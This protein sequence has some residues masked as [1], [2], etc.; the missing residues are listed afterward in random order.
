MNDIYNR[1]ITLGYNNIRK[2]IDIYILVNDIKFETS[3]KAPSTYK[4]VKQNFKE[5]GMLLVY[6][7]GDHGHLGHKYN[8]KF[9]AVHDYMHLKYK[10]TFSFDDEHILSKITSRLFRQIAWE[11]LGCTAWECYVIDKIVNA[12][13]SGQIEYYKEN[14][15]YIV[16]QAEFINDYLKVV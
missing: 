2:I 15:R 11:I 6:S 14:N 8:T 5:K 3:D 9:R 1:D 4:A 7:G 16:N 10:L 12:E 13:I